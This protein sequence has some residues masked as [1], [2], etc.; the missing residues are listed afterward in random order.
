MADRITQLIDPVDGSRVYP[1]AST[2]AT[3][4]KDGVSVDELTASFLDKA[5]QANS[6]AEDAKA[7]AE[8]ARINAIKASDSAEAFP[9]YLRIY[10]LRPDFCRSECWKQYQGHV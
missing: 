8:M 2:A 7:K 10:Y 6:K 4:N 1:V 5:E 3:Y 9:L